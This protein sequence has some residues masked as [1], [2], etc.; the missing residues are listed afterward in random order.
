V[1]AREERKFWDH[2]LLYSLGV[3]VVLLLVLVT[4]LFLRDSDRKSD[5]DALAKEYSK[6]R[7][8]K[9]D[10]CKVATNASKPEC[11]TYAPPVSKVAPDAEA[12]AVPTIIIQRLPTTVIQ[13]TIPATE[14]RKAVLKA[15]GGSCDGRD[16]T[17]DMVADGITAYC[18]TGVCSQPGQDGKDG[19]PPSDAQ[20]QA[21]VANW[22]DEHGCKGDP[23][24]T[25]PAG[26]EGGVLSVMTS[27]TESREIFACLAPAT[28]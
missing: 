23:G 27:L 21:A 18:S 12:T 10:L 14:V 4:V 5:V 15:C 1:L 19:P 16:V 8:D 13:R 9:V 7:D 11:K 28:P 24:P 3:T 25:C 22:C 20:I 2:T 17:A 26:Y 6:V